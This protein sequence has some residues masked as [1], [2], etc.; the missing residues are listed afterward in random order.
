[1]EM[2]DEYFLSRLIN[3]TEFAR[4]LL[5][6]VSLVYFFNKIFLFSYWI[7]IRRI[8]EVILIVQTFFYW[9]IEERK[10]EVNNVAD[11]WSLI[12]RLSLYK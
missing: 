9:T 10:K 11:Q 8:V 4:K 5:Y 7:L 1:M 2:V 3:I 12:T 6:I